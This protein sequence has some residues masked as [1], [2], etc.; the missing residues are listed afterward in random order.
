M[1]F[2]LF[3]RKFIFSSEDFDR[4]R[5]RHRNWHGTIQ[6]VHHLGGVLTKKKK[7]KRQKVTLKGR[8][9]VKKSH[10]TY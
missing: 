4:L 2:L 6:K 3:S 1:S 10:A 5:N 8:R 7:K 9:A